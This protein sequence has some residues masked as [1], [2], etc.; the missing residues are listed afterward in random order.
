MMK[1]A[2]FVRDDN[3]YDHNVL[4]HNRRVFRCSL[5]NTIYDVLRDFGWEE[6]DSDVEWY[7]LRDTSDGQGFQLGRQGVDE[8]YLR[9]SEVPGPPACESL[10]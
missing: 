4:S 5:K 1:K 2:P 7:A 6:T 8:G 10:P 9:Y 3:K